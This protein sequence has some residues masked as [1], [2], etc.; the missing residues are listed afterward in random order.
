MVRQIEFNAEDN[1][2]GEYKVEAIRDNAVY[3]KE[4]D[5][6]LPRLYYLVAW[7]SY[8]EE[9]NTWKSFSAVIHLRKMISTFYKEHPE[10]PTATS[11][12]LE[13][14][15]PIDRPTVNLS[16]KQKQAQPKKRATKHAK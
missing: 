12:P 13:A 1:N 10:K 6:H 3:T 5:G 11:P 2:G 8:P 14:A 16:A 9:K 4:I 7:K 15:P